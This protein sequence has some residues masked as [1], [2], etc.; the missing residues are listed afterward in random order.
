MSFVPRL[1]KASN[2]D[3]SKILKVSHSFAQASLDDRVMNV[4][5][6]TREHVIIL[7]SVIA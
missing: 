1:S 3:Y 5:Y 7:L 4:H 2:H 6:M